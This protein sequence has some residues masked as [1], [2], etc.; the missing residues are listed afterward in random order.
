MCSIG[1]IDASTLVCPPESQ[2]SRERSAEFP[3]QGK[4]VLEGGGRGEGRLSFQLQ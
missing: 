1:N 4:D 3:S 2:K